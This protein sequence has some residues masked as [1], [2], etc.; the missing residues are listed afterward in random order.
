V[1][2]VSTIEW[3]DATASS[4]TNPWLNLYLGPF[5]FEVY[6]DTDRSFEDA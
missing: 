1:S 3:T 6:F 5:A 2:D 4:R